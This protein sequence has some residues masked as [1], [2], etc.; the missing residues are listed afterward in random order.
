MKK[1]KQVTVQEALPEEE[2]KPMTGYQKF[3]HVV[4]LIVLWIYRL[5]SVFLAA[6]VVYYA[7]K[8]AAYNAAHLPETVGLDLQASGEFA[9]QISRQMAVVGPLA[10]TGG[11]LAMMVLSRKAM[12]AWAISIFSLVLPILLLVSNIYPS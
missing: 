10:I 4:G 2:K 6:P 7:L 5:R 11:C 8:L 12:Y 3:K 1:E 9:M